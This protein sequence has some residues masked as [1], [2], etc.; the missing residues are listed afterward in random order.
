MSGLLM[1]KDL[2]ELSAQ[3]WVLTALEKPVCGLMEAPQP[4][5]VADLM[6]GAL[7]PCAKTAKAMNVICDVRLN[8]RSCKNI[9]K[10][11]G[12]LATNLGSLPAAVQFKGTLPQESKVDFIFVSKD[13][14]NIDVVKLIYLPR[15]VSFQV[16]SSVC[17]GG[18]FA[19]KGCERQC[20][21]AS[22]FSIQRRTAGRRHVHQC[23]GT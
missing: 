6:A 22:L 8:I 4:L 2:Q 20:P 18:H 13:G 19:R 17:S 3:Q 7:R 12:E 16:A 1:D 5:S 21:E 10:L 9:E 14:G 15:P 11:V 23:P